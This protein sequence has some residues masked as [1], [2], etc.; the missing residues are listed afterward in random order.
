MDVD[1]QG[2][3]AVDKDIDAQVVLQIID[4]VWL[5]QILLDHVATVSCALLHDSLAV[6]REVDALTLREPVR[7]DDV[8]LLLFQWF[9]IRIVELFSKVA[10]LLRQDPGPG[11]E[12]VFFG[13]GPL[14]L[15]QVPR[16]VVLPGEYVDAWV[17]VDLLV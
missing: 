8:C 16:Q 6:T 2:A 5:V 12:I 4:E 3:Q 14:H 15:H 9:A 10:R 11:K 7:F 17:L 1:P 13:I